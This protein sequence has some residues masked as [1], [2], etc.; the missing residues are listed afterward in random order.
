MGVIEAIYW[1]ACASVRGLVCIEGNPIM[2]ETSATEQLEL[3]E[4]PEICLATGAEGASAVEARAVSQTVND[5]PVLQIPVP[6]EGTLVAYSAEPGMT[7]E[8]P[9]EG[10][11]GAVY[12]LVEGGLL[13]QTADG[14]SVLIEQFQTAATA[15]PPL[16]LATFDQDAR[17]AADMM[18]ALE[19]GMGTIE[20][21]AGDP[22]VQT[23]AGE[24]LSAG[25]GAD[26][27]A[28]GPGAIGPGLA[29]TGVLGPTS[30]GRD[31]TFAEL[32][33]STGSRDGG[34]SGPGN[35]PPVAEPDKLVLLPEHA[36]SITMNTHAA[37]DADADTLVYRMGELPDPAMAT[38][39][40]GSGGEPVVS[41][42]LLT[43]A[44]Y[45]ALHIDPHPGS[46]GYEHE[47]TY[48]V[49]D[50]KGGVDTGSMLLRFEDA[51]S[52]PWNEAGGDG[53]DVI[54]GSYDDDVID[55]GAGNDYLKGGAGDDTMT[56]GDGDDRIHAAGGDDVISG[57]AG[58]DVLVGNAGDDLI[59]DDL[60]GLAEVGSAARVTGGD[61][62]DTLRLDGDGLVLDLNLIADARIQGIEQIDL[63]NGGNTLVLDASEV[64]NI[65]QTSDMLTVMGGDGDSVAGYLGGA[66]V[67]ASDPGYT[68]YSFGGATLVVENTV[69][70]TGIIV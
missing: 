70:Q 50:G 46:A 8:I 9:E 59:I 7:V 17:P 31:V 63:A 2:A 47:L 64:L 6:P 57:G 51:A 30:L 58:E 18:A 27:S 43:E 39:T 19:N 3:P 62:T 69:D 68:V 36:G 14:G 38:I 44:E 49:E 13:I 53:H 54:R 28:Y 15:T 42:Q 65:S 52:G 25:G 35:T 37:T 24:P 66:S 40:I 33:G 20:P 34:S 56:G 16:R 23:G 41:G 1:R 22:Q 12:S 60:A 45:L 10:F 61:G 4:G 5:G 55:G 67:D 29:A 48:T 32:H 21:A 11:S 26:F